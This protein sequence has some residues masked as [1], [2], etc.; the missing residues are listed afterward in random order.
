M[1]PSSSEPSLFTT[2]PELGATRDA[3]SPE[4]A[5]N[6][7]LL[8]SWLVMKTD[9]IVTSPAK[10][11]PPIWIMASSKLHMMAPIAPAFCALYTFSLKSH[12]PRSISAILPANGWLPG[13]GL[14]PFS[15]SKV[16]SSTMTTSPV[17]ASVV[18]SAPK[19]ANPVRTLPAN[20]IGSR[21]SRYLLPLSWFHVNI[22]ILPLKPSGAGE[23]SALLMHSVPPL[24]S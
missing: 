4:P 14:Q 20:S 21:I 6:L 12:K 15:P 24:A 13:I 9:G 16:P 5:D 11:A 2:P 17:T 3:I 7:I 8:H 19:S 10:A 23:K 18:I 1:I 22:L